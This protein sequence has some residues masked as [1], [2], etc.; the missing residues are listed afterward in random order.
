MRACTGHPS[1]ISSRRMAS[2][3]QCFSVEV[4]RSRYARVYVLVF[5][6]QF[7]ILFAV[8]QLASVWHA[9]TGGTLVAAIAA[10]STGA[11]LWRG[12]SNQAYM[13]VGAGVVVNAALFYGYR[14]IT[15]PKG[16]SSKVKGGQSGLRPELGVVRRCLGGARDEKRLTES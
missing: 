15:A 1:A 14:I 16:A 11:A 4:Q 7:H 5:L 12:G 2:H 3:A 9:T 10:I 13:S 8:V 6:H